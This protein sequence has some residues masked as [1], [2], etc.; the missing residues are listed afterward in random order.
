MSLDPD[1]MI[2]DTGRNEPHKAPNLDPGLVASIY[3]ALTTTSRIPKASCFDELIRSQDGCERAIAG[4]LLPNE[5]NLKGDMIND[6]SE[7]PVRGFQDQKRNPPQPPYNT[8]HPPK[9]G[10]VEAW[11]KET[12]TGRII[13]C[14]CEF[15]TNPETIV[16]ELKDIKESG[17]GALCP[18]S[19]VTYQGGNP[20]LDL[21]VVSGHPYVL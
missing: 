16:V 13:E 12:G 2:L 15:D 17:Y 14:N 5:Q 18:G 19:L 4:F 6:T 9:Q 11:C 10:R 20:I 7:G 21:W 1:S 8:G 3:L